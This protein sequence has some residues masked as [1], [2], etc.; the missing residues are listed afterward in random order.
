MAEELKSAAKYP[1]ALELLRPV[2]RTYRAGGWTMMLRAV[3][4]LALKCAFLVTS[5]KDYVEF[6]LELAHYSDPEDTD[7]I[8]ANLA[9]QP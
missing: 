9:R 2:I 5:L 6:G 8:A 4:S 7:R 3:L 1:E